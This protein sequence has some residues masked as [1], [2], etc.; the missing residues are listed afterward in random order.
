M[1]DEQ[2][3]INELNAAYKRNEGESVHVEKLNRL[4]A[5]DKQLVLLYIHY[6]T[7][8][9]VAKKYNCSSSWMGKRLKRILNELR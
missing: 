2:R 6:G 1:T 9:D 8:K 4:N 3:H 7:I 5:A